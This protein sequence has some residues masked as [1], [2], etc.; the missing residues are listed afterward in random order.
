M[1]LIKFIRHNL[2]E[3]WDKASTEM[4]MKTELITRLYNVVPYQ[5]KNKWHY[6]KGI[7]FIRKQFAT[8]CDVIHLVEATDIDVSKWKELSNKIKQYEYECV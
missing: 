5:Y 4:R 1:G 8:K 3:S 7:N 2:P 6:K